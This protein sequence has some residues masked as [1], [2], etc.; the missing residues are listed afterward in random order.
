M[1]RIRSVGGESI[2]L[3]MVMENKLRELRG[4][5]SLQMIA[6]EFRHRGKSTVGRGRISE[7]ERGE[8]KPSLEHA[9]ILLEIYE[10]INESAINKIKETFGLE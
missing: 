9:V 8:T 2:I 10:I 6:D 7:W 5:R 1:S 4:K 3:V